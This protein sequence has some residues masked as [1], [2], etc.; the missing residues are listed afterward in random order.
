MIEW[1]GKI[2]FSGF[3]ADVISK[4]FVVLPNFG[5]KQLNF[6]IRGN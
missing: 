2:I 4:L 5:K 6:Q 1:Q 3:A